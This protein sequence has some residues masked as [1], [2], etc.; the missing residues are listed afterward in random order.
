MLDN[1]TGK[2]T[3]IDVLLQEKFALQLLQYISEMPITY[4]EVEGM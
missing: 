4:S 1:I 2:R 3:C